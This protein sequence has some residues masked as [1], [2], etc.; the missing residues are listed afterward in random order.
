M[1]IP[2]YLKLILI[3]IFTT[4]LFLRVW[5]V[6]RIPVSLFG[7]EIDVGLQAYSISTTGNDYLGNR[8]PIIF[9]S[10]NEFRLPMQ[11]YL[12]VPFVKLFGL[13]EWGIRT[14]SV[15][16]GILSLI[17]LYL[18]VKEMFG[19]KLAWISAAFLMMSPWHFN[20]SRQ[21]NDAG[22]LLPFII[23]GT[24]FFI[25]GRDDYK[26]LVASLILFTLGI[27]TYAIATVFVPLFVLLLLMVFREDILKHQL[28]KL[29]IIGFAVLIVIFPF[30]IFTFNGVTSQRFSS[31]S[32]AG[33]NRTFQEV[34]DKRR[35]SNSFITR[36]LYNN[37]TITLEHTFQNYVRAFSSTFLFTEGDPNMR[38]GIEG[39]GQMYHFDILLVVVGF[40]MFIT[41]IIKGDEENKYF[42]AIL[43]WL[44]VSPIPS[45]LTFDGGNHASR[46]ILMLPPLIMLSA[47]G[48][49]T[50]LTNASTY[51]IKF[52]LIVLLLFMSLDIIRFVHRYFIVWSNESWRFWQVGYKDM[53]TYVKS[54]DRN[55][56]RIYFN[57][58]YEPMLPRFL[59]WYAYDMREF[60]SIFKGDR[61]IENITP[62]LNGY[63][64]G[65]KYYFGE[66]LKPVEYLAS[67]NTLIV[68][69][70]E[71]D[72][73]NPDIFNNP[74]LR[75]L[76]IYYSPTKLPIFYVFTAN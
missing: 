29:I 38:Q 48:F 58:T 16:M 21:A 68:A 49:Y 6:D 52:I 22:I 51:R 42:L 71:K 19:T 40:I 1:K 73:T 47:Y 28:I 64:L 56:S 50:L 24:L 34:V 70:A 8:M 13:N 27:Y 74:S 65:E 11:L 39:F 37:K 54:I 67:E 9:H 59:F 61:H 53:L 17:G 66:I 72:I 33:S 7:D 76:K 2:K 25:K 55:Y 44:L 18:L 45:A 12:G 60:Q 35:W 63:K 32:I 41:K 43:I 20:F 15:F 3:G 57:N 14:P 46:L 36:A 69:S 75:L 23:F 30:L 4:G 31:I 26:F 5:G 10:F 62:G